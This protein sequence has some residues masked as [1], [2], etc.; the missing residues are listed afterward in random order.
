[1]E[2]QRRGATRPDAALEASLRT[3]EDFIVTTTLGN[4]CS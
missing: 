4:E 1:M 2:M 3:R